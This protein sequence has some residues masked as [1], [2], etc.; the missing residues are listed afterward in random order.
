MARV[1]FPCLFLVFSGNY[2]LN[3]YIIMYSY[4]FC[5]NYTCSYNYN[6]EKAETLVA[7]I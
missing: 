7:I 6:T 3:M 1:F 2:N 4:D 5:F